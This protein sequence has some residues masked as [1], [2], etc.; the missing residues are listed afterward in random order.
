MGYELTEERDLFFPGI[1]SPGDSLLDDLEQVFRKPIHGQAIVANPNLPELVCCLVLPFEYAQIKSVCT[2]EQ[3][4][5]F[6]KD[7]LSPVEHLD[8]P[9]YLWVGVHMVAVHPCR[10]IHSD[11]LFHPDHFFSFLE[12]EGF[13]MHEYFTKKKEINQVSRIRAFKFQCIILYELCNFSV[14]FFY[15]KDGIFSYPI[16]FIFFAL[17]YIRTPFMYASM[18][19][20]SLTSNGS[21]GQSSE[22]PGSLNI[23]L[24]SPSTTYML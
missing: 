3:A 9:N 14:R 17:I 5:V 8:P 15:K 7:H 1:F 20:A 19:A 23:F 13:R 10:Q 12:K 22:N 16:F 6:R 11:E 21:V 24:I 2:D 18:V 4:H